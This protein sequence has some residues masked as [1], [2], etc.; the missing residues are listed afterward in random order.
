[1]NGRI[2]KA[3]SSFYYIETEF[4]DKNEFG[5]FVESLKN[6][7]EYDTGINVTQEDVILTLS[8]C[9]ATGSNSKRWVVQA[10]LVK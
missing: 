1:M 10:K 3:L 2:I 6:K 9:T 5:T 4:K 7:S 8:T